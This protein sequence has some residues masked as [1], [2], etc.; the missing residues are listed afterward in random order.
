LIAAPVCLLAGV[1]VYG[2]NVFDIHRAA[3]QFVSTGILG[4]LFFFTL[5]QTGIRHALLVLLLFFIIM[6]G[7]L[8][9]GYRHGMLFRDALYVA[10]V[11]V[12]LYLFSS[13]IYRK[14]DARRW[15]H[16]IILG[17]LMGALMMFTMLLLALIIHLPGPM[18]WPALFEQLWPVVVMNFVVG[19]GLGTGIVLSEHLEHSP[20]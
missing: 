6:T 18:S 14:E 13:R 8:T 3:F 5:R 12:A 9:R 4:S 10:A 1:A 20:G 7:L 15:L 11:G 19:L 2:F 16:P 17:A